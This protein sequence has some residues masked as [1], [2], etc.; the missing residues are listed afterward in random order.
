[1]I[2]VGEGEGEGTNEAWFG[3]CDCG[4]EMSVF[5]ETVQGGGEFSAEKASAINGDIF[6][7]WVSVEGD[8]EEVRCKK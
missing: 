4:L 1:M 3:E 2:G 8:G 6:R 7:S 5:L